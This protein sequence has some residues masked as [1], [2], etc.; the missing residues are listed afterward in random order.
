MNGHQKFGQSIQLIDEICSNAVDQAGVA[1]VL[2]SDP[3]SIKCQSESR[4]LP[5][6]VDQE[7]T[8]LFKAG[9]IALIL[10]PAKV[11][12]AGDNLLPC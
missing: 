4:C 8:S 1:T 10:V 6:R 12:R 9:Y 7:V 3:T 2:P 11:G 5:G